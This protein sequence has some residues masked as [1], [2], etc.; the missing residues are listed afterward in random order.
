MKLVVI[1]A[2]KVT[3]ILIS[4]MCQEIQSLFSTTLPSRRLIATTLY[5]RERSVE[6]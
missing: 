1:D 6:S 4:V 5:R 3:P 2:K